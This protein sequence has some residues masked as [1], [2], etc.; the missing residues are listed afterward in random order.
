MFLQ[1]HL[2][3]ELPQDAAPEE[4]RGGHRPGGAYLSGFQAE[5]CRVSTV[6]GAARCQGLRAQRLRVEAVSGAAWRTWLP[7]SCAA[8]PPPAKLEL[9]GFAA[10]R[11]RAETVSGALTAGGNGGGALPEHCLPGQLSLQVGAAPPPGEKLNTVSPHLRRLCRRASRAS[12]WS[13]APCPGRFPASSPLSGELGKRRAGLSTGSGGASL[14]LDTV[15]GAMELRGPAP[16]VTFSKKERKRK[17]TKSRKSWIC[18]KRAPSPRRTPPKLLECLGR[19]SGKGDRPGAPKRPADEG[20][21]APRPGGGQHRERRT[22]HVNVSVPLVL[23]RPMP[24]ISTCLPPPARRGHEAQG[25]DLRQ[26]NLGAIVDVFE[27]WREDIVNVRV[28]DAHN[29]SG[30][31]L[32]E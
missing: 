32:W 25:I 20:Q 24:T 8:P 10:Q 21:K 31:G 30:A 16:R 27:S 18:W 19:A 11:L 6:S 12:P 13:T 17:T 2:V 14:R 22:F 15:S 29:P 28:K 9:C 5:E 26:L 23:A 4:L 1:K 3:V 7:R